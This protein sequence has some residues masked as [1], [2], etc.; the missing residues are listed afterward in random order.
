LC[1]LLLALL[2]P[3]ASPASLSQNRPDPPKHITVWFHGGLGQALNAM[4]LTFRDFE[5]EQDHRYAVDLTLVPEGSYA[6]EVRI[7]GRTG[8]LPCL[9]S[10]DGPTV[11]NFAWLG[12]LQP[13]DRFVTPT[14]R[15]DLLPSI[16]SQSIYRNHLYG[17]GIY[18]SGL[19]IFANRRHLRAA[20]VRQPTV[21]RPWTVAEFETALEKLTALPGVRYALD[22]KLNYGRGEFFTYAFSPILQ[23]AGGDLID[24]RSYQTAR[25]VL[26][27][28]ESVMAMKR[29]QR[30]FQKGWATTH[31]TDDTDFVNG[32]A[33]LSWAGH[34]AYRTYEKALGN[35]L[36]LLPM[37][38]F[39]HG[40]KTGIGTWVFTISRTCQDP[41]AAWS[42]LRYSLRRDQMLRWADM[43]PGVPSRKSVLAESPLHKP[44]GALHLY[45]EQLQHG[46]TVP[47]PNTPAYP[48]ITLAFSHAVE[49]IV[50]GADVQ[51]A[52]T[53]AA[54]QIDRDIAAHKGYQ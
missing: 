39:G 42:L 12:Y 54:D 3:G 46:W 5:A 25:G 40:P 8:D 24:R 10:V 37:P 13:I 52:L 22:L 35:D 18:E 16:L 1:A 15:K 9:L 44:G 32:K 14:L 36:L 20:G 50:H 30:W 43:H 45:V 17:L 7:A 48:A 33:S 23:S 26:D 28:P 2:P 49:D 27:S 38:D 21:D 11:P 31:P 47:R 51:A 19:A 6:D 4:R 29:F 53:Q 41:D 34:W